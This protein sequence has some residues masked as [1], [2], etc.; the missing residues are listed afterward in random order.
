MANTFKV[1]FKYAYTSSKLGKITQVGEVIDVISSS[2]K[3][4]ERDVVEALKKKMGA[5]EL[6]L[7]SSVSMWEVV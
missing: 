2:S 3:P 1:K 4:S 6:G 7:S 5:Q